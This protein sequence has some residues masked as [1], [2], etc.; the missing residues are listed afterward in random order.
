[1]FNEVGNL[2]HRHHCEVTAHMRAHC[3]KDEPCDR[4]IDNLS[5]GARHLLQTRALL[6][7]P[8]VSG[9]KP[10]KEGTFTWKR[11]PP[12]GVIDPEDTV[13]T[14]GSMLDGPTKQLGRVGFGFAAVD[15]QGQITA[16]AYG[17]PPDWIDSVPGAET[18][19]L[20]EALRNMTP[21]AKIRSDCESVV[22]RFKKGKKAATK[23]DV[24][25]A[26][27]WGMIFDR[28]DCYA[29]PAKDVDIVWMPA[30]TSKWSVGRARKGDGTRL[31]PE[32][33]LGNAAADLLAKQGARLHRVPEHIRQKVATAE[34]V[35][36]RA[37]LQLGVTTNA[38]NNVKQLCRNS[39]GT[40]GYTVLRD[41]KGVPKPSRHK[42]AA[43]D[44]K[45]KN[46]KK[47]AKSTKPAKT[48]KLAE[49]SRSGKGK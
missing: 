34:R 49:T 23:S 47:L 1:M 40:I 27:L 32:D 45:P 24:K 29:D 46:G 13:Y 3:N 2:K 28:C 36:L 10:N 12:H 4:F 8:D 5:P 16:E 38:A 31:T 25:L 11:R 39:D 26:R 14:D 43:P 30:H 35:A 48:S 17:T 6:A 19:A 41:S 44:K 18:W 37:A 7:A 15:A 33:R 22:N 21:G 42:E 9:Y 20:L